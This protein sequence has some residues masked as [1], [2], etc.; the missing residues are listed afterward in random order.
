MMIPLLL[1][2]LL[3]HHGAPQ[4]PRLAG[5]L[6][7]Q[8]LLPHAPPP[9]RAK[10]GGGGGSF[11][12]GV[13]YVPSYARNGVMIWS[14]FDAAVVD[15]ELGFARDLFNFSC[16]RVFTSIAA[17]RHDSAAF[18]KNWEVLLQLVAKHKM[19]AL[20]VAFDR[21]FPQC[22]CEW[23]G[24]SC[25]GEGKGCCATP[26]DEFVASGRYRNSSW[27][28]S[29]GAAI[30][31]QDPAGW[32][33]NRLDEYVAQVFGGTFADDRR[34]HA[35]EVINEPDEA[36]LAPFIDWA[37][38]ALSKHSKRPLAL[39]LTYAGGRGAKLAQQ[40]AQIHSYHNYG[41]DLYSALSAAKAAA[42][43][44][45]KL[46]VMTTEYG[47]RDTQPY[48]QPFAETV[49]AQVDSFAW[50]LMLGSDEFNR[51]CANGLRYQ[52]LVW[53]N[54]TVYDEAEAACFR[55]PPPYVPPNPPPPPPAPF[56]CAK[57]T[58]PPNCSAPACTFVSS[59]NAQAAA[60]SNAKRG[61]GVGVKGL[62][63][64]KPALSMS[65][66]PS[67][68]ECWTEWLGRRAGTLPNPAA[69]PSQEPPS[70]LSFCPTAGST[71][72]FRSLGRQQ[73][74]YK[75]G[76]DDGIFT[77]LVGGAVVATVDAYSPETNWW[78]ARELPTACNGS[79]VTVNVTGTKHAGSRNTYVQIVGL[80]TWE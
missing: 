43:A 60:S 55:S 78:A 54:G 38:A 2:L 47:R 67:A 73:L 58:A 56:N 17:W 12:R 11:V 71:L 35:I 68:G 57:A 50:E 61:V 63:R 51:V 45:G 5:P 69:E 72:A 79:D 4:P 28:P 19:T 29:P 42:I 44:L 9:L 30:T 53:P 1:P 18:M 14:D 62:F 75:S 24:R 33:A 25:A 80:A 22:T 66:P 49:A 39:E 23:E 16:V 31:Q 65:P 59:C 46:G 20:V 36:N 77:I 15:R 40:L 74:V 27:C 52:G 26:D 6:G 8:R 3:L 76:P 70:T 10:A 41:G 13:N 37:A 64:Y 32:V 34:I 21:D 7:R 48:C